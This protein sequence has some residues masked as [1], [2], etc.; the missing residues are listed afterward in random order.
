[1][2]ATCEHSVPY[3]HNNSFRVIAIYFFANF[4]PFRKSSS[5]AV[6]ELDPLQ[7]TIFPHFCLLVR[8]LSP[9]PSPSVHRYLHRKH[10]LNTLCQLF[11]PSSSRPVPH[12]FFLTSLGQPQTHFTII[13]SLSRTYQRIPNRKP[14]PNLLQSVTRTASYQRQ[15]AL[16][17]NYI[18]SQ[19]VPQDSQQSVANQE[20]AHKLD[21]AYDSW[22]PHALTYTAVAV[23]G[24]EE[25]RVAR[26]E[27][28]SLGR[29][30]CNR[31]RTGVICSAA[32]ITEP[33]SASTGV[34][35]INRACGVCVHRGGCAACSTASATTR[36][37][38][39]M[40]RRTHGTRTRSHMVRYHTYS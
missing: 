10:L 39:L 35:Q 37:L 13:L 2:S 40:A 1:M 31:A 20:H 14:I 30:R 16:L 3:P 36:R 22:V 24:A 25:E 28:R 11:V 17:S 23:A 26:E 19:R 9:S 32:A 33:R 29:I 38:E 6:L 27:G 12:E 7:Y 5:F 8:P 21:G 18:E 4:C 15:T 34:G